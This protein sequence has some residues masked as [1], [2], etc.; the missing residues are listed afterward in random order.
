MVDLKGNKKKRKKDYRGR[1][2]GRRKRQE[3][4]RD[5]AR[6]GDNRTCKEGFMIDMIYIN[7]CLSV[8]LSV[9]PSV[10]HTSNEF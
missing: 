2:D 10:R 3:K 6:R 8:Y 4:V 9:Y 5:S 1:R 7:A